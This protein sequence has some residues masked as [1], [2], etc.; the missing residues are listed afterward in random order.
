MAGRRGLTSFNL[1]FLGTAS[2]QPSSTRNHS[3]L[4]LR[5]NAD[6]WLF[7]R[8]EATQHQIQ[9]SNVK[10]GK[11]EKIFITHTHGSCII[12]ILL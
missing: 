2:A 7:D 1:T 9:K 4:A 3:A 12:T 6:V 5:L 8:G 10:M 11:I